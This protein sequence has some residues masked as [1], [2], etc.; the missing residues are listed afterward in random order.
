M[1]YTIMPGEGLEEIK[2]GATADDVETVMGPPEEID[3][4]EDEFFHTKIW[5]YDEKGLTFFFEGDE[6]P[7]LVSIESTH[8]DSTLYGVR[9]F[10]LS[11]K[12]V[13]TLMNKNGFTDAEI[14][15]E[16]W[17][18]HRVSYDDIMTDFYFEN[19]RLTTMNW[20]VTT[21]DDDE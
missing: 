12:D 6:N 2:F 9:I 10:E 19:G 13:M 5:I 8:P 7:V 15:D 17:G 16:E 4:D 11:E 18:E 20:S 1:N 3:N 21:G 14:E